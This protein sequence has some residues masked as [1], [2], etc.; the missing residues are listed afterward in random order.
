MPQLKTKQEAKVAIDFNDAGNQRSFE[1]LPDRTATVLHL[2]IRYGGVGEEGILKR[3]K[4]GECEMLDCELVI[5]EPV[6]HKGRKI[7]ENWIVNGTTSGQAEA[8]EIS[9]KR[10][11][12]LLDS[13]YGYKPDDMSDAAKAARRIDGYC[14]LEGLRFMARLGI[15]PASG[16]YRAKNFI[17]E[18]ITPDMPGYHT[19]EQLPKERRGALAPPVRGGGGTASSQGGGGVTPVTTGKPAWAT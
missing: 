11:K 18:I 12:A 19:I 4:T 17:Q 13:A 3:S 14:D 6:E 5:V 7:F 15:E 16:T 1:P 10:I 9:R 8:C 2:N